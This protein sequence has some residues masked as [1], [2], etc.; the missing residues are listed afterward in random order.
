MTSALCRWHRL[1]VGAAR[2]R[3]TL[4]VARL[5]LHASPDGKRRSSAWF[6][7]SCPRWN[8]PFSLRVRGSHRLR[9][10]CQRREATPPNSTDPKHPRNMLPGCTVVPWQWGRQNSRDIDHSWVVAD[11]PFNCCVRTDLRLEP[12]FDLGTDVI[13]QREERLPGK[14]GAAEKHAHLWKR[15]PRP[16]QGDPRGIANDREP[17]VSVTP[18]AMRR[19]TV[20]AGAS[21]QKVAPERAVLRQ[22]LLRDSSLGAL[23]SH[24]GSIRVLSP[25]SDIGCTRVLARLVAVHADL[26]LLVRGTA[27]RGVSNLPP[28]LMPAGRA[29]VS[30]RGVARWVAW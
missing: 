24:V 25:P 2:S 23:I 9:I 12:G 22:V 8:M 7:A 3:S 11:A 14:A 1:K 18:G 10:A 20:Q 21:R 28:Q 30:V 27:R 26:P 4:Y 13:S 17:T 6:T 15:E 19:Q 29:W 5:G 16:V